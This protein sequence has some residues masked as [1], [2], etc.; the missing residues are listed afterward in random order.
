M[1]C[2]LL[3]TNAHVVTMDSKNTV[4]TWV[5]IN[6]GK[7]VAVGTQDDKPKGRRELDVYR[8]SVL[9][10]FCDSHVHGTLTGEALSS[11]DLYEAK[12]IQDILDKME[13]A[14]ATSEENDIIIAGNLASER[15][16]EKRY[17]TM[18]QLDEISGSHSMILHHQSLHGC[19]LNSR[20]F[21]ESGLDSKMTGIEMKDGLPTGLIYD[22]V[23]YSI[24]LKNILLPLDER[25]LIKIIKLCNDKALSNGITSIH[26]LN[27]A[28]YGA[29]MPG[30]IT[31]DRT[32]PLHIVHYWETLDVDL[33]KS[34][35]QKQIGGCICLDGSRIMRTMALNE[36]YN[37]KPEV[38]GVLYYKDEDV[39]KFVSQAHSNGMQCA[40]HA[41]GERAIDQLIYTIYRVVMEQGRNSLR[42]RIEHFSMPSEKHIQMAVELE[43]ALSMQP[44]F[45]YLWD[46][47]PDSTYKALFG[48]H[49]ASCVEPFAKILK[50]GGLICGGSDSP[51]TPMNPIDGINACVNNPNPERNISLT[52]ALKIFT[53]NSAWAAHEEKTRGSIEVGKIADLVILSKNIYENIDQISSIC[54][55]NTIANGKI[56]YTNT[57]RNT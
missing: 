43:L 48:K 13:E 32:V 49:R 46:Q 17:P 47:G 18:S 5:A 52:D 2:D 54:I 25:R 57:Q 7:I 12:S 53:F 40:M 21:R 50:Y 26:S 55:A 8:A 34:F 28:D 22:D 44:A 35:G 42:H 31:L 19:V 3:I 10:G 41:S 36:P 29:D 51:V 38:R 14:C 9:P 33:V 4:A 24:A 27:G 56:V 11:I 23:P 20:G 39:Y 16:V 45:S 30:W 6:D 15:L 37:D 1:N